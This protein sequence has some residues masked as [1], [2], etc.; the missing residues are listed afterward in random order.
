MAAA[1]GVSRSAISRKVVEAGIEQLQQLQERRREEVKVLVVY[2][3]GQRFAGHRMI[4][5]VGV[6]SEGK[7]HI[8]GIEPGVTEKRRS[9]PVPGDHSAFEGER[10]VR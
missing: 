1:V 3:D 2:V 6:D 8:P 4:S 9:A 5:A 10:S 7:K